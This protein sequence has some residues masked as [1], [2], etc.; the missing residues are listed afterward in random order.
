MKPGVI[1]SIGFFAVTLAAF[2]AG[3]SSGPDEGFY[4]I[5]NRKM[6]ALLRPENAN[7]ADGTRIVLYPAEPWK[8]MTWKVKAAG[9]IA[10]ELQNYLTRKT[11]ATGTNDAQAVVV[12]APFDRDASKRPRWKI[13]KLADG[14]YRIEN[15]R[16]GQV[17]TGSEAA[18][19]LAPWAEKPE[20]E[21]E[22]I[23]ID[24]AKLTM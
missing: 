3:G 24:P 4:Q 6:N 11:F 15:D 13:T 21:W 5:R 10:F 16:T 1:A 8:C 19:T 9:G 7:S 20:Q 18:V 2:C 23:G 17:M 22:L 12:Q 14:F